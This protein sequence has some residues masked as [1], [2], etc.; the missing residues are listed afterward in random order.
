MT[1]EHILAAVDF[2]EPAGQALRMASELAVALKARLSVL[3]VQLPAS[4][5]DSRPQLTEFATRWAR[6]EL[7]QVQL[8]SLRPSAADVTLDW[9]VRQQVDLIVCGNREQPSQGRAMLGSFSS[10]LL[11]RSALPVLAA[12]TQSGPAIGRVLLASDA[13]PAS[14]HA[15]Q[16]ALKL[17]QQL[18][19]PLSALH[20]LP[21][22]SMRSAAD[23]TQDAAFL[24]SREKA[25]AAL[26][27]LLG[28]GA[29]AEKLVEAGDPVRRVL[30]TVKAGAFG[31]IV[32]ACHARQGMARTMMGSV[33][34]ELARQAPC[35]LLSVPIVE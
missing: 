11:G 4:S 26:D 2:S 24:A 1:I 13:R 22:L 10:K 31:L 5:P 33:T 19:Q 18:G 16:L 29:Q 28:A 17:A 14:K 27:A 25:L 30:E 9:A 35:S 34:E 7:L 3:H 21:G 32:T 23:Q 8:H 20:V 6:P 12:K 15:A